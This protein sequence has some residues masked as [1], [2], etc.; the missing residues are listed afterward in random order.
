MTKQALGLAFIATLSA[1]LLAG[2]G[3]DNKQI[4]KP[5]QA[6]GNNNNS[7]QQATSLTGAGSTF[8]YPFFLWWL[9]QL[10]D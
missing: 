5:C 4:A 3:S 2:C 8:V 7:S 10:A 6:G 1:S 9:E